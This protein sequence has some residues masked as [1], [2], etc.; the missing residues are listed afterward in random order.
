M[1]AVRLGAAP[2]YLALGLV[3]CASGAPPSNAAS[4]GGKTMYVLA[5]GKGGSGGS[6]GMGGSGG[7]PMM[8]TEPPLIFPDASY[9]DASADED[10]EVDAGPPTHT[11]DDK[12]KNGAE[13]ATDCG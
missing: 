10:A 1:K 9:M 6:G 8:H 3:A 2:I 7:S 5:G 4:D 12:K 13:T 11:C